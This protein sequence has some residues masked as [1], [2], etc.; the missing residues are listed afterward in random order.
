MCDPNHSDF[1]P[2]GKPLNQ[3][4]SAENFLI[5]C[6]RLW[7]SRTFTP[8]QDAIPNWRGGFD[9]IGLNQ[10]AGLNFDALLTVISTVC[11]PS[12]EVRY[13]SCATTSE[14]EYWFLTCA[15]LAQ[16]GHWQTLENILEQR[17]PND[18]AQVLMSLLQQF[19]Q[20]MIGSGLHFSLPYD[21][22]SSRYQRT[23]TAI[24]SSTQRNLH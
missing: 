13:Y 6:L 15:A 21:F 2:A 11:R 4:G 19:S 3:L 14:D 9:A 20:A 1:H 24:D 16:R 18:S 12:L 7:W 5:I 23:P 17:T 10:E 22:F 8:S